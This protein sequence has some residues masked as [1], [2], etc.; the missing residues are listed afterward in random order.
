MSIPK[1][2]AVYSNLP[3]G[4]ASELMK[5]NI[6]YFRDRRIKIS[7][8]T[9]FELLPTNIFNYLLTCIFKLPSTHKAI[10]E[11]INKKCDALIAYHSWMTKSPHLLRYVSVPKVYICQEALREYYDHE[12]IKLQTLKERVV[13]FIRLP[14]KIIDRKNVMSTKVTIIANSK[15][16]KNI[17]DKAYQVSSKVI[18]PGIKVAEFYPINKIKKVNQIISVGAIN[19][20][21]R[22]EFIIQVVSSI[23]KTIRPKLVIVGNGVDD[24]YTI[25]L[26]KLAKKH[27]VTLTIKTNIPKKNLIEEYRKS[28][29]FIYAPVSEPF[30]IVVEEAMA[31]ELPI[32][33]YT[34]GGGYSEITSQ[35]NG[36]LIDN[37]EIKTWKVE[38]ERILRSAKLQDQYGQYNRKYVESKFTEAKMNKEIWQ[39][40]QNL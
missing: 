37:L 20:F 2:I 16:S 31:A 30:G 13:N 5:L 25:K 12:H 23:D 34:E 22:Y 6:K 11:K 10:S 21:K 19:K 33:A 9:D 35:E 36:G 7:K 8:Y 28:K 3:S 29:L 38:L 14:I 39:V 17:I 18:Y 27:N 40:I 4:G 15:F 24:G 26:K 32:V 1:K